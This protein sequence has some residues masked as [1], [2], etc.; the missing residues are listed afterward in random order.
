[1]KRFILLAILLAVSACSEIAWTKSGATEV[2]RDKDLAQCQRDAEAATPGFN[3]PNQN[4]K[5]SLNEE[6]LIEESVKS[7]MIGKG[8]SASK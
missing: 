6:R 5:S 7:C 3:A 4:M 1:M 8:W 2:D